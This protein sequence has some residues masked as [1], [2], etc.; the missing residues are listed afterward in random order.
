MKK[1]NDP[2]IEQDKVP[3]IERLVFGNRL[4]VVL[5]FTALT[6]YFGFHMMKLRPVASF[7]RMIPVYHEFIKNA[8][9]HSDDLKGLANTVRVVVETTEDDIFTKDYMLTLRDI[10]DAVFFVNGVDRQNL[11]SLWASAV[12]YTEVTEEGFEGGT[13][14]PNKFDGSPEA[15]NE[16]RNNI[17]RS[18]RIGSLIANDFKSTAI[19]AP[20]YGLDPQTSEPLDYQ[21]FSHNLETQVREKF[22]SD[23]IKIHVVGFAKI[24]G[25]LID[26]ATRVGLFFLAAFLI[27]LGLLWYNSKC[28]RSTLIRA[29]SSIV[30]VVWQMGLFQLLGY[31][32][33]PY[34]MLVPF[35]MF[36]LG[37]SHGIQM[38]NAIVQQLVNGHGKL[39][40]VRRAYRQVYLP[41]LSALFTDGIGFSLLFIIAIG[42]I[43]DIA[44]GATLGV[45]IVALCDLCLLPV[46][47]SYAGIS[48]KAVHKIVNRDDKENLFWTLIAK[49]TKRPY[50][51]GV[52]L[53]ALL[54]FV[55]AS[56]VRTDLKIGD[57]DAGAPE[58]RADSRYNLDNDYIINNYSTSSDLLVVMV[59]TPEDKCTDYE[60]LINMERLQWKLQNTPGVQSTESM[61]NFI[62]NY[63][64]GMSEGSLKMWSIPRD[65]TFLRYASIKGL[66]ENWVTQK[67]N[68]A[69]INVY[70]TDHKAET[71]ERVV[72]VVREFSSEV[73][74]DE[75]RFL[76]AAGNSGI[77]AATNIEVE[78][79]NTLITWV[80]Y[81]VVITVCF[82]TF[83]DL[84]AA[85]CIVFPLY[86]TSVLCEALMTKL[87][88]GIKVATLPVIA[89]G[90]GIGIDYG[91]YIYNK[92]KYYL[93]LGFDVHR[94][95]AETLKTTGRAVF[96]TGVTLGVGVATWVFSPIKFQADMGILLMFMFVWNMVG[97]LLVLPALAVFLCKSTDVKTDTDTDTDEIDA[98]FLLVKESMK[99]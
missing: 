11:Q 28:W 59:E 58:L 17:F 21:E 66:Y 6:V 93:D 83:R 50:A 16:L 68:F 69:P 27:L 43:R 23:T 65:E 22:Q 10:H 64:A 92:L 56:Y 46:L 75:V 1:Q 55:G 9:N 24:V 29:V 45:A 42:V 80:V 37:V 39:M 30:A 98:K 33:N 90:V 78:K 89:V 82:V 61:A 36:A 8:Y 49:V 35:L 51:I 57:L 15:L 14:M 25:D 12:R 54:L 48:S 94:A 85:I 95:Y 60:T 84:R 38:F 18:G 44:I 73:S 99:N 76:L 67:C 3:F 72:E 79:A 97:A 41:G 70:L 63:L 53:S 2:A 4:L 40:A 32:L 52:I 5:I 19:I 81:L 47:M 96:F 20:L 88:I 86:I 74:T 26:G 7:E 34:S 77:D 71:L 13:V 87:G 31:G 62:K 91:I